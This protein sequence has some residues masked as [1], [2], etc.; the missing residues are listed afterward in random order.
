M[1]RVASNN[2]NCNSDIANYRDEEQLRWKFV[3]ASVG[4][5]RDLFVLFSAFVSGN[6]L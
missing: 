6:N 5:E 4:S 1:R 3:I 2:N